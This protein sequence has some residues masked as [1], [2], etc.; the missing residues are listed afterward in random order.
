[1][2]DKEKKRLKAVRKFQ[3]IKENKLLLFLTKK[4]K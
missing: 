1:M 4:D 2:T 3:A